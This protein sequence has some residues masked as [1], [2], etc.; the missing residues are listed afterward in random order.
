MYGTRTQTLTPSSISSAFLFILI[1]RTR[2]PYR[3]HLFGVTAEQPV[4]PTTIPYKFPIDRPTN[5][6]FSEMSFKCR[7]STTLSSTTLVPAFADSTAS[8]LPK[9]PEKVVGLGI[10]TS[11]PS[12]PSFLAPRPSLSSIRSHAS[13]HLPPPTSPLPPLPAYFPDRYNSGRAM[14]K[15][16]HPPQQPPLPSRRLSEHTVRLVPPSPALS[17]ANL[18]AF[19]RSAESLSSVYSRSISGERYSPRT[20]QRAG[21]LAPESRTVSSSSTVTVKRSPL[22]VMRLASDPDI[23]VSEQDRDRRSSN[24]SSD[25]DIDDAATLQARLPLVKTVSGFGEVSSWSAGERNCGDV[26]AKCYQKSYEICLGEMR[27]VDFTPLNVRRTRDSAGT[28][29]LVT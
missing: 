23:I 24:L 29:R 18:A 1:H 10:Y 28:V 11:R 22:G 14:H 2:E 26:A 15:A 27:K 8:L 21:G 9:R 16:T 3:C 20:T 6:T 12:M 4:L 7:S 13:I 25:S 5:P 19:N 17:T